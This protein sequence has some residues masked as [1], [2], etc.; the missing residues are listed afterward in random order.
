MCYAF[1]NLLM[2]M[3]MRLLYCILLFI[4]VFQSPLLWAQNACEAGCCDTKGGI[5]YCD[6]SAGRYVCHDGHYSTCYCTRHAV[7]NLQKIEGCCL[8]Q[9]G[10]LVVDPRTGEV[11]CNNGSVSELCSLQNPTQSIAT[12]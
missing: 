7:M 8:W 6:S 5:Q 9:G 4:S 11:I 12:W 2:D 10:V 1:F 3:C